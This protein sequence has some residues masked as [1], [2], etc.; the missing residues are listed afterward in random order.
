MTSKYD[1]NKILRPLALGGIKSKYF[2]TGLVSAYLSSADAHAQQKIDVAD[3]IQQKREQAVLAAKSGKLTEAIGQLEQIALQAPDDQYVK[4]DLI[5]LLRQAGRNPQISQ[6]TMKQPAE[7]LPDYALM[8]WIAAL[9]D[10]QAYDRAE[11][12]L[13]KLKQRF[14]QQATE[15]CELSDQNLDIYLAMIRAESGQKQ[16]AKNTV[17]AVSRQYLS[18]DQYA[19]IA[20]V[21]LLIG[22]PINSLNHTESALAINPDHP[23][24]IQQMVAAL[25]DMGASSRAYKIAQQHRSFFSIEELQRLQAD[26]VIAQLKDGVAE[27][28]RLERLGQHAKGRDILDFSILSIEQLMSIFG[29]KS[30][31]YMRLKYDYIYALR[32]R[33]R[34]PDALKEYERLNEEQQQHAPP[35]TRQAVADAYLNQKQPQRALALYQRLLDETQYPEAALYTGTYYAY[36]ESE[37]YRPA[38]FLLAQLDKQT[39]ARRYSDQ[40]GADPVANWDRLDL[41]QLIALD[42]TYRNQLDEAEKRL[43]AIYA[44]SPRNSEVMSSYATVL[45]W[46]GLT[47]QADQL[48]RLA[49]LNEPNSTSLMLNTANSPWDIQQ[50]PRW[51]QTLNNLILIIPDDDGLKRNLAEWNHR[52][53]API[54]SQFTVGKSRTNDRAAGVNGRPDRDCYSRL[55]SPWLNDNWRLFADHQYRTANFDGQDINDQRSSLGMEWQKERKHA[56]I[57][58][59]QQ[60]DGSEDRGFSL[61]W[62]QWL[63]D[64]WRYQLNYASKA[65]SI[66]LR[67]VQDETSGKASGLALDWQQNESRNASFSY[68]VLDLNDSNISHSASAAM[69]QR[70]FAKG[71]DLYYEKNKQKN[72]NYFNPE[73]SQSLGLSLAHDWVTWR[74]YDCNLTRHFAVSGGMSHQSDYGNHPYVEFFIST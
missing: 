18:A 65:D 9:R 40:P 41:D 20:Y 43:A 52:K 71:V 7:L 68:N 10:T 66:P 34:M 74:H 2:L 60:V 31:Q 61:G 35:H 17:N 25:A 73:Q 5:V 15:L 32:T 59:S 1:F 48:M 36:I 57:K 33:E 29:P 4:A 62:S 46:R 12:L 19:Q 11:L 39:P 6:I 67:A 54:E 42:A 69:K 22:D 26:T 21:Y 47:R 53:I 44:K 14:R 28:V 70:I 30:P 27:Q 51:E 3:S 56:W 13:V 37:N 49:Q 72:V 23:L 50:Y 55:N 63:N 16:A 24:A 38:S 45:N 64:N 58:L 8:S